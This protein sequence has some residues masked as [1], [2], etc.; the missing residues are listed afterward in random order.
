MDLEITSESGERGCFYFESSG[1]FL[2]DAGT[3]PRYGVSAVV[4]CHRR[5]TAGERPLKGELGS[6]L[7][8]QREV[9]RREA[10]RLLCN[11]LGITRLQELARQLSTTGTVRRADR[12]DEIEASWSE[13]C[14]ID[15]GDGVCCHHHESTRA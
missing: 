6:P 11:V 9:G 1:R 13:H 14:W 7:G 10:L 12:D 3:R 15:G 2:V 5:R 4:G 8:G